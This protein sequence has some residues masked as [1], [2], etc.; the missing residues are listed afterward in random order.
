MT[1]FD[2]LRPWAACDAWTHPEAPPLAVPRLSALRH[3]GGAVLICRIRGKGRGLRAARDIAAG[4]ILCADPVVALDGRDPAMRRGGRLRHYVFDWPD[5]AAPGVAVALGPSSLAN[6]SDRPNAEFRPDVAN[7]V[8]VLRARRAIRAGR[9]ITVSYGWE[10][11][12]RAEAG[13]PPK[14]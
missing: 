5:P 4:E 9:E 6:H 12:A 3:P 8:L 2:D 14:A 7:G 1:T 13:L 11:A 10:D